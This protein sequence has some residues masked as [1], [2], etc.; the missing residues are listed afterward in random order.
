MVKFSPK[1][2]RT[3]CERKSVVEVKLIRL[4]TDKFYL[5]LFI[6]EA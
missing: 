2:G 4:E 1:K 6:E 3:G 5:C